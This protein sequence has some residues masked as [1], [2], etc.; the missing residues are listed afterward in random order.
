MKLSEPVSLLGFCKDY[1]LGR[2]VFKPQLFLMTLHM[3]NIPAAEKIETSSVA[4]E[5]VRSSAASA[6]RSFY[7]RTLD[8][9]VVLMT[10]WFTIPVIALLALAVLVTGQSPFYCQ[11]RV[12]LGGKTFRMWKLRT[13]LPRADERLEQY[14]TEHPEFREEWDTKQ[15]LANDPRITPIGHYLRKTSLDELP[16]LFNVF[17]GS[18]SLVGPRPMMV[19]QKSQ[20]PGTAYYRLRP[21]M[22]GLWQISDRSEGEFVGR[23]RFDDI[24]DRVLSFKTDLYVL[25]KTVLVVIRGTGC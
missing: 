20:Y 2:A 11:D 3:T 4:A 17:N 14:L 24:Y 21:G 22:T 6:Y 1:L 9:V 25:M 15:K 8:I 10:A 18:M 23:V 16:Q 12:G 19:E 7:K 13:M 5:G